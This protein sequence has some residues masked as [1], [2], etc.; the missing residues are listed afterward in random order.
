MRRI[1]KWICLLGVIIGIALCMQA[2]SKATSGDNISVTVP[3]NLDIIFQADGTNVINRFQIKNESPVPIRVQNIRITEY[4]QWELVEEET[5]IQADQKQLTFLFEGQCL[6]AGNNP[7]DIAVAEQTERGFTI[8]VKRGAWS[9]DAD[10]ERA[11]TL[12]LEYAVGTKAFT[13]SFDGNGSQEQ[14]QSVSALNGSTIKL[15]T[16]SMV[17]YH[18]QGWRDENGI[19]YQ[20]TYQVPM[21]NT[22][23]TA[24]WKKTEAYAIFIAEDKSLL[25]VRSA[26][27]IEPG[28]RYNGRTVTEVYGGIEDS[29][30]NGSTWQPWIWAGDVWGGNI[31]TVTV[32]DVIQPKSTAYWFFCMENV[33]D[34]EMSNLD[35]S[36]VEDMTSMFSGTG[37]NVAGTFTLRG[38][39][40]WDTSSAR[41]MGTVF[42]NMARYSYKL[43]IDDI[44]GWNTSSAED[45]CYMFSGMGE[46][47]DWF[48]DLRG[49]DVR[50][51]KKY[52]GF[53]LFTE[54]KMEEPFWVY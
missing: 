54:S 27:P 16:P 45:M 26:E 12:E 6:K 19:L 29:T 2:E 32:V 48:L 49:W 47:C 20:E 9:H 4:N 18:F 28:D 7:L 10:S 52:D 14:F 17:K 25:F 40:R 38:I 31:T 46:N 8:E 3:S 15:P 34:M 21:K 33:T 24:V 30:Y 35:M 13:V 42:R 43:V 51:V 53:S 5:P 22:R 50:K 37:S 44:T 1:F 11:L 39:G 23:L 41:L 36:Q